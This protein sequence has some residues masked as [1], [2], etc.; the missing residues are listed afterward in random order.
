M[1]T[2]QSKIPEAIN[3]N[4]TDTELNNIIEQYLTDNNINKTVSEWRIENYKQLR[5]WAYPPTEQL[6]DAKVKLDSGDSTL[7]SEGQIQYDNYVQACLDVKSR[8]PKE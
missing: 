5:A 4:V 2:L 6:N 7:E 3:S 8:F 1:K